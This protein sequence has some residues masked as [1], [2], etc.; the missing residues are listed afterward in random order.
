MERQP[1]SPGQDTSEPGGVHCSLGGCL[2][3]TEGPLP[4]RKKPPL[5]SIYDHVVPGEGLGG[6]GVRGAQKDPARSSPGRGAA[7]LH[8]GGSGVSWA[9]PSLPSPPRP[10]GSPSP[11][12]AAEPSPGEGGAGVGGKAVGGELPC[13]GNGR[14]GL[15]RREK[16]FCQRKS[17]SREK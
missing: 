12:R 14:Q 5:H 17:I 13:S 3:P 16:G 2:H 9:A 4:R 6:V 7:L 1:I 10:L 8:G 15:G 11:T